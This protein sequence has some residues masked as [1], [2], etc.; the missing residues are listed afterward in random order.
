MSR[1]A[2]LPPKETIEHLFQSS[3]LQLMP[4]LEQDAIPAERLRELFLQEVQKS[5]IIVIHRDE[6]DGSS[7][8]DEELTMFFG[9]D[10]GDEIVEYSAATLRH[11]A[12][13]KHA[14][15]RESVSISHAES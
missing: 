1:F 12:T 4:D 9:A 5:G 7:E 10:V 6:L 13:R 3:C 2:I 8:L 11:G 15:V 14:I